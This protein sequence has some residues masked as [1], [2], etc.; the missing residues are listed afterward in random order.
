MKHPKYIFDIF[1]ELNNYRL[2]SIHDQEV[3]WNF[4]QLMNI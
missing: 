2:Y 4:M 1:T 3:L